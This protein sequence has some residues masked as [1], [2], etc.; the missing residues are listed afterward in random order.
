MS[1]AAFFSLFNFS[2]LT[3]L[4]KI[5][6]FTNTPRKK[7]KEKKY[8][9]MLDNIDS[10]CPAVLRKKS[11]KAKR[12]WKKHKPGAPFSYLKILVPFSMSH[13]CHSAPHSIMQ[14]C[15]RLCLNTLWRNNKLHSDPLAWWIL[16]VL[17]ERLEQ[18][19]RRRNLI[20]SIVINTLMPT[21]CHCQQILSRPK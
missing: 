9:Y 13:R 1:W 4:W 17:S 7:K 19:C 18:H 10:A 21:S 15:Q 12:S 11:S 2:V 6:I 5:S 8:Q 3:F 16:T 20:M 14:L